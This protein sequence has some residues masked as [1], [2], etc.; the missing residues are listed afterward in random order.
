L[1]TFIEDGPSEICE[2][3]L[4]SNEWILGYEL[5]TFS[6]GMRAGE[7][8]YDEAHVHSHR[9]DLAGRVSAAMQRDISSPNGT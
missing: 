5:E 2:A 9:V 6:W 8:D 1:E 3:R 4:D 7:S